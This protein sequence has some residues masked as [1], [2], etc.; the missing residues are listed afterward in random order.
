MDIYQNNKVSTIGCTFDFAP[1]FSW[2][3]ESGAKELAA[4]TVRYAVRR[5]LNHSDTLRRRLAQASYRLRL[6][7]GGKGGKAQRLRCVVP[8]RVLELPGNWAEL[9]VTVNARG[10]TVTQ[11]RL[12]QDYPAPRRQQPKA[13]ISGEIY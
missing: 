7:S 5:Y 1:G 2:S 8:A 3:A 10:V 13:K 12:T 9:R 6:A 11:L 4:D